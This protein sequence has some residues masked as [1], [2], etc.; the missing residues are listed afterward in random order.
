MVVDIATREVRAAA[1][2][3]NR[4][5]AGRLDRSHQPA[6]LAGLDAEAFHLRS[7]HST[8][9]WRRLIRASPIRRAVMRVTGLT[10]SIR[11]F[12]GDVTV[13]EA[14]QHSLNIPAVSAL[15]AV[16]AQRF[17]AA[18]AFAGADLS[19]PLAADD[20][21]GLAIALGGMGHDGARYRLALCR[22][23]RWRAC[24]AASL[25]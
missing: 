20:D 13:T 6:A 15:D 4:A 25:D 5:S 16:G 17:A 11:T 10:I 19:M 12:R 1:G 9:V 2:S 8:M 14:L 24:V 3:A 7:L 22:A 23:W 18:L 21:A